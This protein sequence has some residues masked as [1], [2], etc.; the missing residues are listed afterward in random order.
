MQVGLSPFKKGAAIHPGSERFVWLISTTPSYLLEKRRHGIPREKRPSDAPT[1]SAVICAYNEEQNIGPLLSTLVQETVSE[2]IVV[3]SGCTDKTVEIARNY[4][5]LYPSI[6]VIV[7]EVRNGKTSAINLALKAV[8]SDLIVFLPADVRPGRGSISKLIGGFKPEIG[9]RVGRPVPVDEKSN[10]MGRLSHLIWTLHNRTMRE[11]SAEGRLGHATGEFF[12]I[13]RGMINQLPP[14]VVNDDAYIAIAVQRAGLK[15]DYEGN[16][17]AFMRGPGTVL[18]YV[19][20][21]RRVHFGHIQVM[22]STGRY[23]T[24]F[25]TQAVKRPAL[26]IQILRA[27]LQG[28]RGGLR[29]LVMGGTLETIS[30]TLSA[31]DRV[32]G[33]THVLWRMVEST[34]SLPRS[35]PV[36]FATMSSVGVVSFSTRDAYLQQS[37]DRSWQSGLARGQLSLRP[38]VAILPLCR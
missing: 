28:L 25:E 11:L 29:A 14:D 21:R 38:E 32:L 5:S 33:R 34:K 2:I 15:I 6:K 36:P 27:E 26:F 4:Q 13:R 23:P 12:A 3:A 10:L 35:L 9:I 30:L 8:T 31:V 7:E 16:A 24:V 17:L 20:Q 37:P 1:V 22:K 19:S 18:D